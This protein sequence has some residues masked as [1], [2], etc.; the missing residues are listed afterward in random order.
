MPA[1]CVLLLLE[2]TVAHVG[3]ASCAC[4]RE[5]EAEADEAPS[6]ISS[7]DGVP[8]ASVNDITNLTLTDVVS[9]T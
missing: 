1:V 3:A 5:A 8:K 6:S 7:L 4:N 9:S 2:G